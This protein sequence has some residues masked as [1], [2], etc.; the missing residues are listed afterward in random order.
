MGEVRVI[1]DGVMKASEIAGC[2]DISL[3]AIRITLAA[4]PQE[5]S[6][7]ESLANVLKVSA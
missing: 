5:R 1:Y 4:F 2:K 7:R 6:V 3:D